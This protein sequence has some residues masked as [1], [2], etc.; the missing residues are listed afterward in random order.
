M[1]GKLEEIRR[2]REK[3]AEGQLSAE[4]ADQER[5]TVKSRIIGTLIKDAR[6]SAG[7][8]SAD[9]A[10]IIGVTESEYVSFESGDTMPSLPQLEMLA[11]FCNV[12]LSH[13]WSG[14]TLA[15][16]RHEDDIRSRVS[17]LIMLRERIIGVQF[18]QLRERAGMSV[19]EVAE[20]SGFA[21]DKIKSIETGQSSMPVTDL[22]ALIHTIKASLDDM[23][24]G[25]G[26]IGGWLQS[27]DD[28]EGFTELPQE[29]R[30]FI[31]KPINRSYL[32]LAMRLSNMEV[33]KLR[34]IAESILDI[35]L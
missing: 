16:Q 2:L 34:T 4:E 26:P 24:E 1:G 3:M 19:D 5:V 20:R 13:F 8:K 30:N 31:L 33:G 32:D 11:Y 14:D 21:A 9:M 6:L 10:A 25:H 7:R 27:R 12:P 18:R 35:T 23:V 15:V 22:E 29:L 17:D 28:Y